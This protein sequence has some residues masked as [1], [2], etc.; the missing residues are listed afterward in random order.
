MLSRREPN[1]DWERSSASLMAGR[2]A[3]SLLRGPDSV[4]Q[5]I[6]TTPATPFRLENQ[7]HA[8]SC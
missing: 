6:M 7:P 4:G 5:P 1:P 8:V 3:G 2:G